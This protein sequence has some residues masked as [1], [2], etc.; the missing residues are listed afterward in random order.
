MMETRT[1]HVASLPLSLVVATLKGYPGYA[2]MF[3]TQRAAVEA[4]GGE[5]IVVDGSDLPA[6]DPADIGPNTTWISAPGEGVFRLRAR[7]Y[8][9][10]RGAIIGLTE[11]HC[12][13]RADW[14]GVVLALHDEHPE[15]A[16]I[17]GVCANGSTSSLV[18]WAVFFISHFR[19]M[20]GVGTARRVAFAGL[21]NVSY[22]RTALN[23][24][25]RLTDGSVNEGA[26]QRALAADGA[27]LL[28]D[29]RLKVIHYQSQGLAGMLKISWHSA[30]TQAGLRRE[31]MNRSAA[32]RLLAAPLSPVV[33]VTLISA[34]VARQRYGTRE[35]VASIPV[36]I[37]ML[38]LRAIAEVVGYAAGAGDSSRRFP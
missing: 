33:F 29:D 15:A 11:D 7:A 31:Q 35:F 38:G 10:A 26:H 34:A 19:D 1:E 23:G 22:K 9:V 25:P 18:D 16:V 6:P 14:G 32:A 17:G 5:M 12:E 4:V 13:F 2:E 8:P 27:I 30:R 37:G 24:L 3:R 21:G 28:V 36:M 20:P